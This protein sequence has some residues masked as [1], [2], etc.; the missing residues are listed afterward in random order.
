MNEI[1]HDAQTEAYETAMQSYD[2]GAGDLVGKTYGPWTVQ[3][4]FRNNQGRNVFLIQHRQ[5][6]VVKGLRGYEL[7]ALARESVRNGIT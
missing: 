6:G 3:S 4:A 2:T 7:M 5:S 1:A